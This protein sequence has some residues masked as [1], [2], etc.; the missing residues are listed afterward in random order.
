VDAQ[1]LEAVK[2]H[3]RYR[4][5]LSLNNSQAIAATLARYIALRRTPDTINRLYEQYEQ[6]RPPDLQRVAN[7]YFIEDRQV[8]ITLTGEGGK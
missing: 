4:F 6:L 2:K 8:L 1:R 3:L 5:A 7:Q